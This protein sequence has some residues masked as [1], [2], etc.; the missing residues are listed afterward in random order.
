[1]CTTLSLCVGFMQA[2]KDLKARKTLGVHH[3]TFPV[4][5]EKYGEP[6]RDLLEALHREN[7]S[8]NDFFVL[9]VGQHFYLNNPVEVDAFENSSEWE[10][11]TTQPNDS[12]GFNHDPAR[13][14]IYGKL[15]R[16]NEDTFQASVENVHS[17]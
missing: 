9:D 16:V 10:F 15:G 4:G 8:P 14:K 1:M 7:V 2:H 5:I 17:D 3:D 6:K 13:W 11:E 12:N